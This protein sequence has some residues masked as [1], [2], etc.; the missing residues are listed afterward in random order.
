MPRKKIRSSPPL[1][2]ELTTKPLKRQGLFAPFRALGL[3]TNHV[4]FVLQTRTFKG[5]TTG[6]QTFL[7]TCLGKSWAMW[8]GGK[9]Q[10]L[11][12]G[13]EVES[14]ITH[15]AMDGDHVW[16][17]TGPFLIKY[18][19]GKEVGRL[20]D[21]LGSNLAS[22]LVFGSQILVLTEDGKRFIAWKAVEQAF[23]YQMT[24][25]QG[26]IATHMIHPA[27][28][29]N[30]ILFAGNT[31]ELQIWNIRAR[32]CIHKFTASNLLTSAHHDYTIA[33]TSLAQSPAID[34]LAIGFASGEISVYDIRA[35]ERLM[36]MFVQ[37]GVV[38]AL[39]FRTDGHHVLASGSA[40]GHISL[41]DLNAHGRLLH[42]IHGAHDGPINALD[43]VPDQPILFSSGEDNSL[44]QWLFETSLSTPRLL[45]YRSG[46]R[47]PPHLVRYFG[48]DGKQIISA[49]K[50]CSLRCTSVVRDSRSLE[51][52]PGSLANKASAQHL[53]LGR[54]ENP[55]AVTFSYSSA[56]W[57]DWDDVISAHE[58]EYF[59]RT[60]STRNKRQGKLTFNMESVAKIR[61]VGP[62]KSLC[63]SACGNFGLVGT[64]TGAIGI[65][66][67][68][69]GVQQKCFYADSG[70]PSSAE[71]CVTGIA[72]D[73]LNRVIIASTSD[74][75]VQFFD[76]HSTK[77]KKV[78]LLPTTITAITLQRDS[79]LLAVICDDFTVRLIDI[80][81][82]RLVREFGGFGGRILDL[83]FSPD[84]RWI[85]AT[86]LDSIIRTYDVTTGRMVDAFRSATVATS[87][88]FSPTSDFL[89]TSHVGTVGIYLWANR[90]QYSDISFHHIEEDDMLEIS[91]PPLQNSV[92][93]LGTLGSLTDAEHQDYKIDFYPSYFDSEL[94]T[95]TP[96]PRSRWQTLLNLDSIHQRNQ[97][98]ASLKAVGNAPFFLPSIPGVRPRS[99]TER[100]SNRPMPE[101]QQS[102][103][104]VESIFVRCL[105]EED[106]N[107]DYELF[108]TYMKSLAPATV[109]LE[110]RS[111][112]AQGIHRLLQALA[113]R[114]QFRQ[115]FEAVQTFMNIL[116]RIHGDLII[117][118]P[119]VRCNLE[120]LVGLQ[121][122]E[123]NR[124]FELLSSS[125]G[126]L[127]F[128]RDTL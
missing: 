75:T 38:T 87:L 30:K 28:Y 63:V 34:V 111:L 81:T 14:S 113:Q 108:F 69:S 48:D 84:S 83:T 128:V 41:W 3:V 95:L 99:T 109:D 8:E 10:L 104:E 4:P 71:R 94:L 58:D 89:A 86:A 66:N 33:I 123:S 122:K 106:E 105:Y 116:L 17:T 100:R 23:Q 1:Q 118:F 26:F 70:S 55:P 11:F 59:A 21:P 64:S 102:Q 16:I 60:W 54:F 90:A 42:T 2:S 37:E 46:H 40:A 61:L 29:L 7:L 82:Q 85:V 47:Y 73:E 114:L 117:C 50:D 52:S 31:G 13:P 88:S 124:V 35:D 18:H 22:I 32:S 96:L 92:E 67:M 110:I 97:P 56:R 125:S 79:G 6:P 77:L 115:D 72:T 27:T 20:S 36:R 121:K 25:A 57:K 49:S 5:S 80:E 98:K 112:F 62:V 45:N 68:Q 44:K 93:E 15:M 9:M 51:L 65:W 24:F 120:R 19:R 101:A 78:L 127:T 103:E 74:G 43:W 12:A 76:F 91:L 119:E 53:S 39:S 107:G 126:I